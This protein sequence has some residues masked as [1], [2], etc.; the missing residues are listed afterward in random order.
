MNISG[1]QSAKRT[2][3][4]KY[5]D[6]QRSMTLTPR[7]ELHLAMGEFLTE[8]SN[9]ENIMI[10]LMMFC[11]DKKHFNEV[12]LDLLNETFGT[13]IKEFK[14]ACGSYAFAAEH[15]KTID[16]AINDIEQLLPKRNFIVHGVT[17]E[18]G[19]GA[20][21]IRA[22]R[23]GITKGNLDYLNEFARQAGNVEHAFTAEKI[24][25]ATNQCRAIA[26]KLGTITAHL[27][28]LRIPV[29]P[30]SVREVNRAS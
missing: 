3:Q 21:E 8:C 12:H 27:V 2:I 29:V 17:F 24:R 4:V 10:T 26:S 18:V 5:F 30:A 14:K 23:I 9:L 6:P 25:Q 20:D 13:R 1:A 7:D 28:N 19:F 11:Q 22:Y 15:Q 16:L